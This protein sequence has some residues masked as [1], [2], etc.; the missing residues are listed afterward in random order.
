MFFML[1]SVFCYHVVVL[2]KC[3]CTNQM[4]CFIFTEN[5][6]IDNEPRVQLVRCTF[7]TLSV[8][9]SNKQVFTGK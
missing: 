2:L 9:K 4:S 1:R 6:C 8:W 3:V 7:F 5:F